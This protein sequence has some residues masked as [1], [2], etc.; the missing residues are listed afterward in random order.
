MTTPCPVAR[1]C[2]DHR[3][4]PRPTSARLRDAEAEV[5]RLR[6]FVALV[7]LLDRPKPGAVIGQC[8]LDA[9]ARGAREVLA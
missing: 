6:E 5:V 9:L 4:D 8:D 3:L 7:A 1:D 2:P